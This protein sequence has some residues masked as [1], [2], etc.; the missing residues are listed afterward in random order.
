MQDTVDQACGALPRTLANV[1]EDAPGLQGRQMPGRRAFRTSGSQGARDSIS[2]S[3]DITAR[4]AGHLVSAR[5]LAQVAGI[6]VTR[7]SP[8]T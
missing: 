2:R 3:A 1:I 7:S 5:T 4:A 6:P 8:A